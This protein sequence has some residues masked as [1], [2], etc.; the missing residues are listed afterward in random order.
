[1]AVSSARNATPA[2]VIAAAAVAAVLALPGI[3]RAAGDVERGRKLAYTCHGCHGIES[4]RNAYPNYSVPRLGGQSA[5]YLAAALAEYRAGNR[6]HPT[7]QGQAGRLDDQ[8]IADLAA[9][10]A[11]ERVVSDGKP[12][13]TAPAAA[14]VCAACHGQDGVG[15]N[16][17]YPTLSGQAADYIEQALND[18]RSGK[19]KNAI[20]APMAQ[21]VQ[22]ADIRA[23]AQYFSTQTPALHLPKR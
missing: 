2:R 23:L 7:M 18:Y 13:G 1:M 11:G 22:K 8:E 19:R 3:A 9:Y 6:S 12:T 20:M 16:E 17:D 14:A 5:K 21:Q 4:Y 10:L 15:M